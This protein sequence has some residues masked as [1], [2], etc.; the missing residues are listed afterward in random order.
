MTAKIE[1]PLPGRGRDGDGSTLANEGRERTPGQLWERVGSYEPWESDVIEVASEYRAKR[2]VSSQAGLQS[3]VH[4]IG[5][6]LA[7]GF[8]PTP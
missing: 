6:S 3:F 8:I 1:V 5:G 2:K 4:R 7:G